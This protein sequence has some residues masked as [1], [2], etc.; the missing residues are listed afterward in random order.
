[1]VWLGIEDAETNIIFYDLDGSK[2]LEPTKNFKKN[3][4]HKLY[5]LELINTSIKEY[6]STLSSDL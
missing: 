1:M 2:T 3:Y 4:Q 5:M 6:S